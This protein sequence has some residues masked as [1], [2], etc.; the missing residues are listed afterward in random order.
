MAE[1]KTPKRKTTRS[2]KK[3]V[4]V[5][6]S[7]AT[8]VAS[9]PLEARD[10]AVE[11]APLISREQRISLEAYLRA[12]RRGFTPGHEEEDWLAAERLI[13]AGARSVTEN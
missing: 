10:A 9:R 5:P 7:V 11:P 8:P 1:E 3:S 4:S 13:D 6:K 2:P 12:E